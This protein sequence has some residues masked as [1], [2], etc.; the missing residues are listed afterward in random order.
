MITPSLH[1]GSYKVVYRSFPT[2]N[3]NL[4]GKVSDIT[5]VVY[6]PFPTSNHND[7]TLQLIRALVVYRPFPTS[8]HNDSYALIK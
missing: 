6:R 3:H 5:E 7:D 2:S 1:K 8:N 4:Y